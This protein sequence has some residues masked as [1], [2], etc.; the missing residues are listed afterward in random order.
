HVAFVSGLH[1]IFIICAIAVA[2]G[3]II[4]VVLVRS[5]DFDQP[6]PPVAPTEPQPAAIVTTAPPFTPEAR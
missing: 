1:T 6:T 4:S 2:A 3:A 5:K